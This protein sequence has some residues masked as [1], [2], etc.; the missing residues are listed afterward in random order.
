[1]LERAAR[2]GHSRAQY[3]VG[4]CYANG[5]GTERDLPKAY[6]WLALAAERG[7]PKALHRLGLMDEHLD[8]KLIHKGRRALA[9][10]RT[11]IQP[12]DEDA[13]ELAARRFDV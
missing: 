10:L 6:A 9:A 3:G 1:M 2:Q 11:S 4:I 5:V 8:Q 12:L 7:L 13:L